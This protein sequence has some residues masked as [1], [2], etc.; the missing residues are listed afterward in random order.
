VWQL[1]DFFLSSYLSGSPAVE[2]VWLQREHC[3]TGARRDELGS[4]SWSWSCLGHGRSTRPEQ[5]RVRV[6]SSGL[7]G[8]QM[9]KVLPK[10]FQR[11]WRPSI[12]E[13][14]GAW[15]W[16]QVDNFPCVSWR[17][18]T[19]THEHLELEDD[20]YRDSTPELP[21]GQ[22]G[23]GSPAL[24]GEALTCQGQNVSRMGHLVVMGLTDRWTRL[25]CLPVD[26]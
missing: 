6:E 9:D 2:T 17:W 13:R 3:R 26:G 8:D 15:R 20:T 16:W 11:F 25:Q 14:G 19:G 24:P 18:G 1:T 23:K 21:T 5:L 7:G 12:V 22:P 4:G 10:S